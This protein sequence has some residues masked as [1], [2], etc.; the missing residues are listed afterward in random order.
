MGRVFSCFKLLSRIFILSLMVGQVYAANP[1]CPRDVLIKEIQATIKK[2]GGTIEPVHFKDG[3]AIVITTKSADAIKTVHKSVDAYQAKRA[4]HA[5][6]AA[7]GYC[8][9]LMKAVAA[10]QLTEQT[11]KTSTGA[12]LLYGTADQMLVSKLHKDDCCN[13]CVCPA[14]TVTSCARCC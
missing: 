3:I 12:L 8:A 6:P 1:P 14:G 5:A 11:E 4:K 10:K 13:W 7:D 9:S 2:S